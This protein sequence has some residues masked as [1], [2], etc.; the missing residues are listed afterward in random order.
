MY[1]YEV[2]DMGIKTLNYDWFVSIGRGNALF[3]EYGITEADNKILSTFENDIY[4][5]SINEKYQKFNLCIDLPDWY[6]KR[7]TFMLNDVSRTRYLNCDAVKKQIS[8][9]EIGNV[10][11][12]FIFAYGDKYIGNLNNDSLRNIVKNSNFTCL[13]CPIKAKG[14][15]FYK[16]I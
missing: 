14:H 2:Y 9:N 15:I 16:F 5:I 1:L 13:D 12:C 4:D 8:I 11:P 3:D 6:V 7:N 10:Y